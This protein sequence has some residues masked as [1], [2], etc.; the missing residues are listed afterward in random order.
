V[1]GGRGTEKFKAE[2]VSIDF[3]RKLDFKEIHGY[4]AAEGLK[5]IKPSVLERTKPA[6]GRKL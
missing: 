5:L 3:M 1:K 6:A 2:A 4:R